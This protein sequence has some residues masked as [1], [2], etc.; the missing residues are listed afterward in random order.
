MWT[1]YHIYCIFSIYDRR[2]RRWDCLFMSAHFTNWRIPIHQWMWW[3]H[4]GSVCPQ[5]G[6]RGRGTWEPAAARPVTKYLW[7]CQFGFQIAAVANQNL[8]ASWACKLPNTYTHGRTNGEYNLAYNLSPFSDP[9]K[10]RSLIFALFSLGCCD[11]LVGSALKNMM[12][13]IIIVIIRDT[14]THY[15]LPGERSIDFNTFCEHVASSFPPS[16]LRS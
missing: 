16:V 6:R 3:P 8:K 4:R 12:I 13:I 15:K 2:D 5:S 11:R 7:H 14:P 9:P 1:N 10:I